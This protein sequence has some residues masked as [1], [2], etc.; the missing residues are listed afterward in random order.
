MSESNDVRD[1]PETEILALYRHRPMS[2]E[3]K[4]LNEE[5]AKNKRH[6]VFGLD[7]IGELYSSDST[8]HLALAVLIPYIKSP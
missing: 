2:P 6:V 3:K 5:F 7:A 4:Y 8:N 1:F